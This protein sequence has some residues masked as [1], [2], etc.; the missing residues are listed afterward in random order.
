MITKDPKFLF[1]LVLFA[2]FAGSIIYWGVYAGIILITAIIVFGSLSLFWKEKNIKLAGLGFLLLL[3]L[4]NIGVNGIKFG[5]DFKGGTRI[6]VILERP[7]DSATMEKM[8]SIIKE[9]ASAFGLSEVKVKAIGNN[10]INVEIPSS[11]EHRIKTVEDVLSHKGVYWGV[12]DGKIAITGEHIFSKS[13]G[14]TDQATLVRQG[15]DWGVSFMVDREGA[16]MFAEAA[17]GKGGYPVYMFLDR[18]TDADIFYTREEIHA[19]MPS[20]S[21]ERETLKS[22][23]DALKLDEGRTIGVYILDDVFNSTNSTTANNTA[24]PIPRTN[25]TLAIVSENASAKYREKLEAE[26][27]KVKVVEWNLMKA[28]IA[29][30]RDTGVLVVDKLEAIGLLS[31]PRLSPDLAA[32]TLAYSFSISGGL[33]NVS[34]AQKAALAR[35]QT[36]K[37]ESILKGGSLPVGITLGSRTTIPPT[38]GEEFLNLSIIGIATS[39]IIISLLIGLRYRNMK[40]ALPITIISLSEFTILISILGSLT[41]DLAAIAGILAAI[42]VGV[43]AQIVITDELLKRDERD[44]EEKTS[45]A[46]EIIKTN[47]IVATLSMVPLLFSNVI[48]GVTIVEIIGFAMSTILGS[49]L[50]YLLSR[51]AY[52]TIVEYFIE[53]KDQ[54]KKE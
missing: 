38:L 48:S 23:K 1:L 42:G 32:G 51:P 3:S 33:G 26:G 15:A 17:K 10:Q 47:V 13:I 53:E 37:M 18:P 21:S 2:L 35:E 49:L 40:A 54:Q 20:D 34:A 5:I 27:Y 50:G 43:D 25:N 16:E 41:I 14:P 45:Y 8:V 24:M 28:E 36:Q 52:A 9:R 39:L 44:V 22:L 30:M 6:P 4:I 29:R 46:F 31:A 11:D 12:I 19:M 7:V